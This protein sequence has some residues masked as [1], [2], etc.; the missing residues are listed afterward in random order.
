MATPKQRYQQEL[1]WKLKVVTGAIGTTYPRE[2]S[3]PHEIS[4]QLMVINSLLKVVEAMLRKALKEI[5]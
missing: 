4:L 1:S 3:L 5:K 2:H